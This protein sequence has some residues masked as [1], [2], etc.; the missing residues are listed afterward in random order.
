M[1]ASTGNVSATYYYDAF[2]NKRQGDGSS[3]FGIATIYS[4]SS[5]SKSGGGGISVSAPANGPVTVFVDPGSVSGGGEAAA[6]LTANLNGVNLQ[7]IAQTG[8]PTLTSDQQNLYRI[9]TQY[10]GGTLNETDWYND[11]YNT[12]K[13][14]REVFDYYQKCNDYENYGIGD[15]ADIYNTYYSLVN[16]N[17]ILHSFIKQPPPSLQEKMQMA[18]TGALMLT[19]IGEETFVYEILG[20]ELIEGVDS[21]TIWSSAAEGTGKAAFRYVSEGELKIIQKTGTIPNTDIAGNLKDVFVSPGKYDTIIDAE[22]ALRI[23]KQNPFGA[24]ESPM[25]RIEF[26][27]NGIKFGYGGNVEG[28]TGI[29]MITKQSIPVDL[30]KIFKLY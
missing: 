9:Y 21:A 19:G 24:T 7:G 18:A 28:G 12:D 26:N 4:S 16:K 22:K 17:P 29:E 30:S 23:G 3:V 20:D 14:S 25:Y 2:G 11:V 15:K 10:N 6:A 13:L 5:G 8:N 1:N 27:T